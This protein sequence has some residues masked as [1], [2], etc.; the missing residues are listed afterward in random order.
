MPS[1]IFPVP[2]FRSN[3]SHHASAR[4]G[5]ALRLRTRLR[6]DRLDREL[7]R[8][9]NPDD[10][11]ELALRAEQLLTPAERWRLAGALQQTLDDAREPEAFTLK[12]HP[13]RAEIRDC[14]EDLLALIRRLRDEQTI[15][16]R[17]AALSS[18]LLSDRESPLDRASGARLRPVVQAARVALD[19]TRPADEDLPSA[20]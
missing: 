17:G 9:A 11:P 3:P 15:E 14:A 13:H 5:A 19:P 20:A 10:S 1:G 4:P 7:S 18:W 12:L 8:E 2:Q 16:V 6:R